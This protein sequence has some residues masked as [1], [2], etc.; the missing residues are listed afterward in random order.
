[1]SAGSRTPRR[2]K[3]AWLVFFQDTLY[4]S[5]TEMLVFPNRESAR[6]V[7][8]EELDPGWRADLCR[9]YLDEWHET[10]R[11]DPLAEDDDE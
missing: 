8:R 3:T 11:E 5:S 1:M 4:P 6:R 2:P 10:Y 9:V 7:A